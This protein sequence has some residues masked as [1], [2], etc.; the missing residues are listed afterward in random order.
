MRNTRSGC[1][2]IAGGDVFSR[3]RPL[4]EIEIRKVPVKGNNLILPS[5]NVDMRQTKF[6]K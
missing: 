6:E 5:F 2:A 3:L 4:N 1:T